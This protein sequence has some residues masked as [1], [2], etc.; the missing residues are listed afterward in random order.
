[1]L[2]DLKFGIR[3]LAKNPAFTAVAV[4]S[5]ALGIGA[6][7]AIFQL[8]NAV[9]LKTLPLRNPQELAQ[10]RL[11]DSDIDVT[12]GNKGIMRYSPLTNPLWEQIRDHQEGFSGI[13]AWSMGAF[14]LAQGG[15]IR[16]ARGLWLS[17]DFFN[18]MGVQP[19]LGR[20]FNQSDDQRGCNAPGVVISH[21]FWQSEFGGA[22]DVVGRK[23]NLSD[24]SLE[25]IG[26]TSPSFFG[27]EIGKSFDVAL[28][29]C[30]DAIFSGSNQRLNSGTDWWL[31]V[32]GRLKP[33][34]TIAQA[35]SQLTSIS[36]TLFQQ[37][38]PANYPQPSVNDYL[39][40]RLIVADGSSGYSLLRQN[41][42]RPLWLLLAIAGLVLLITCANLANLL[43]ARASTREREIAVR[44]AVGAS[45][46]RIIRQLLIETVL[47]AAIGTTVGTVLAQAL[48]QFLVKSIGTRSN[49][50]FLDV[51]PDFRVLGFA[52]AVAALTCIFFGLTPALRATQISPGA[53]MKVAGRGLTAGRERFS[54]RR[55]LVV[56]QVA[57][58]L[59]LVA[60]ALLFS[61][62]FS[63]LLNFDAGFNQENL[64]IT[65]IGFNRLKIEPL[66][67]LEFRDQLLDR[68]KN[69]PGVDDV[70]EMDTIPLSGGGRGSNVWLEGRSPDDRI[71]C[72]FNRIGVDYLKTLQI[73]LV[74]GRPFGAN[75]TLNAPQVAIIN[76][77]L[78]RMLRETNPVG[79]RLVVEANPDEGETHYEIVGM[80]RDAK[81][82]DLREVEL[83]MVYLASAQDKWPS[84]GRRYLVRSSLPPAA[85][86]ASVKQ[87]LMDFTPGL[88]VRFQV[89]RTMVQDSLLRDR[90][91]A[92]LSGFFG[93]LALLLASIGLYGLLS[94][95]VQSRTNEIGIRM[96]LGAQTSNV[97]SLILKEAVLLVLVGVAVGI[98]VIIY[99]SR[100]AKT[101][102]FGLSPTD[103]WSLVGASLV[104]LIVAFI[105]G[106]LPARRATKV[107]PLVALRDE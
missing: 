67:R 92:T 48:S 42:E 47:L 81:F 96:A 88:D 61:R 94:Y 74:A 51:T 78:A 2:N 14:N 105:A 104:L 55:G 103:P 37:T 16:P 71:G 49:I 107:D 101:L 10:V 35:S 38:L 19:E 22:P 70:S 31:M 97:M 106:Y 91:M 40:S 44:L 66:R 7:T 72:S 64:L 18:V 21:G 52:A 77:T 20:L 39:N 60:G 85:V 17:G 34:W 30:A 80:A 100:F 93:V 32:N 26:V 43:L 36:S 23:V 98:P 29:L 28:P 53:A 75:D 25:V 65:T 12:R 90:L 99:L 5:L 102:L 87:S 76:E 84:T 63:K 57:L 11:R 27:L 13:A 82:E 83:P 89:F 95:G 68:V 62:S 59:V 73:P 56:V 6:N 3:M 69:V 58:S 54:L 15:E 9:R 41:Y 1:M 24:H 4:L 45:R 46:L 86:T 8:L 50:V 79:K 33:G